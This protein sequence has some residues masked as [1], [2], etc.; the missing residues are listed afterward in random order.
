MWMP[1]V[2]GGATA[3]LGATLRTWAATL[4]HHPGL[5]DFTAERALAQ[6]TSAHYLGLRA[7]AMRQIVGSVG[8]AND[9]DRDFRPRTLRNWR[10]VTRIRLLFEQEMSLPP[11][12]LN[13][14]GDEYYIVD[15]HHRLAAAKQLGREF[16]D[17]EVV[18][19]IA[20]VTEQL[21]A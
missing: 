13:K 10:R 5:K 17:A 21:A 11:V 7:V 14:L 9:F 6:A 4:T 19:F 8:R 12:E 2:E 16:V 3:L 20:D 15:G 1:R 18:E